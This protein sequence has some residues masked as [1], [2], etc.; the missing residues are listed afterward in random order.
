MKDESVKQEAKPGV[1]FTPVPI[2][3]KLM[4]KKATMI[5]GTKQSRLGVSANAVE[6]RISCT[7]GFL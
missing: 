4:V 1:D 6:F 7:C 5:S 2:N 3:K